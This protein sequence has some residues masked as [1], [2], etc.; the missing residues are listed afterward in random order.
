MK[1]CPNCSISFIIKDNIQ[2]SLV[3]MLWKHRRLRWSLQKSDWDWK[4]Q[5]CSVLGETT[6]ENNE[7]IKVLTSHA[8]WNK[9]FRRKHLSVIESSIIVRSLFSWKRNNVLIERFYEISAGNKA[10]CNEYPNL[11]IKTTHAGKL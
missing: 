11:T 2:M 1:H 5:S 3:S 7:I 8:T 9:R 6:R 10:N 4:R